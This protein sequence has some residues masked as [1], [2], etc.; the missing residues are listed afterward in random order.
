[1]QIQTIPLSQ[2]KPHPRNVRKT[3]GSSIRDLAIGIA[4]MAGGLS[5]G[6]LTVLL[7][8]WLS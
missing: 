1:M 5:G 7:L 8:G 2:L 3:G 6:I 4:F